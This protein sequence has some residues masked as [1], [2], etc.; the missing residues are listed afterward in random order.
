M[1][2]CAMLLTKAEDTVIVQVKTYSCE[3]YNLFNVD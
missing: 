3:P 1:F 2:N